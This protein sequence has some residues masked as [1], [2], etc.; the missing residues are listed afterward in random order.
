MI[1][2]IVNLD[3]LRDVIREHAELEDATGSWICPSDGSRIAERFPCPT[4]LG[5]AAAL[6]TTPVDLVKLID[7]PGSIGEV[8]AGEISKG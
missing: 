8:V 2:H 7:G 4:L 1:G 5:L 6:G 3:A